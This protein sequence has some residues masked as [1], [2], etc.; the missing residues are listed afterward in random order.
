MV[1]RPGAQQDIIAHFTASGA[2][3]EASLRDAAFIDTVVRIAELWAAILSDGRKILLAGNGGSAGDAQ[4]IAGELLSRLAVDRPALAAV[5][6]TTDGS[7]LTAIGNDY[8]YEQVFAR[9]VAGLGRPGDVF[10]G[11]STSG[12]SRNIVTALKVARESGLHT[13]GMTGQSGGAM[14]TFCDLCLCVP[15]TA[16]PLI[17]QIHLVAAHA[18]CGMV[19]SRLFGPSRPVTSGTE[20][21]RTSPPR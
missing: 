9:Q 21:A 18:M 7:V 15:A 10:V 8:G 3:I 16:T 19:E 4:H 1:E 13:V 17:Q 20:F 12:N 11:L 14:L 5:A 6:L 2:A